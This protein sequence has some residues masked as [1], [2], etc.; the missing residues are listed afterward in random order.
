MLGKLFMVA[1]TAGALMILAPAY[2]QRGGEV[3]GGEAPAAGGGGGAPAGGGGAPAAGGGGTPAGG[4]AAPAAGGG[5]GAPAGGGAAPAAGGGGAPAGGRGAGP[6]AA[7]G[8]GG[9]PAA[10][11][12]SQETGRGR[13]ANRNARDRG[14]VE[15]NV[16]RPAIGRRYHGGVWYGRGGTSGAGNGTSTALAVAGLKPRSVSYGFVGRAI[17]LFGQRDCLPK[18]FRRFGRFSQC[19]ARCLFGLAVLG[20]HRKRGGRGASWSTFRLPVRLLHARLCQRGAATGREPRPRADPQ[21]GGRDAH[22]RPGRG[23]FY[24][25]YRARLGWAGEDRVLTFRSIATRI[26]RRRKKLEPCAFAGTGADDQPD[27]FPLS[28]DMGRHAGG[29]LEQGNR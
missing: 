24:G 9:Q 5:G 21:G 20:G 28:L 19:T 12:G 17:T 4:G 2:A 6:A 18:S 29:D 13:N 16:G 11:G 26:D 8:G 7:G 10:S 23:G 25:D 1:L 15:I 22:V 3:G 27:T 14:N